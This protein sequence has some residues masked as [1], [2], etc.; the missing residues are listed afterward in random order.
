[1]TDF[2][3]AKLRARIKEKFGTEGNFAEALGMSQ[4]SVSR[5]FN[6]KVQFSSDDIRTWS[7][8]LEIPLE[9]AGLYFFA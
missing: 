6:D 2:K 9:E 5:K 8:L 4:N 3:Y 1:M 7:K